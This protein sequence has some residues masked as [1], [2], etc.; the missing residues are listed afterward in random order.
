MVRLGGHVCVLRRSALGGRCQALD[1]GRDT[2]LTDGRTLET[3]G[4]GLPTPGGL[5]RGLEHTLVSTLADWS[6][7]RPL[8]ELR[9]VWP[10]LRTTLRPHAGIH[11]SCT[12]GHV[13]GLLVL[14]LWSRQRDLGSS[15]GHSIGLRLQGC[16]PCNLWGSG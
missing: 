2:M 5:Q 12:G 8:L 10:H 11:L 1:R 9:P 3:H 13:E 15:L 16:V 14:G 6:F 4:S 7:K